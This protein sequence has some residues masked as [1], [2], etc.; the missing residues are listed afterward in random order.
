MDLEFKDILIDIQQRLK[1]PKD[2]NNTFAD[3]KYRNL[4]DIEDKVK[5]LLKEHKVY[6]TFNDDIVEVGGRV[7]VK[8]TVTLSDGVNSIENSA[9][10]Q[11]APSPKAKTDHAQLTGA[12]SSYARKYA[13][14]GLFL[15]DNTKDADSTSGRP[16]PKKIQADPQLTK[17]KKEILDKLQ[18]QGKDHDFIRKVL[19]KPTVD[20]EVEALSV[21]EALDNE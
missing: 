13:V 17:L 1:V 3:F 8:A 10:A 4:E 7:Y 21:L 12:C 15:I 11:E 6:L 16:E 19:S 2:Q 14:S 20:T 5:P 18:D 9:F